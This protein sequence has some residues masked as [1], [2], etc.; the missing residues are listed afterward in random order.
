[1]RKKVRE[2]V[3]VF[4]PWCERCWLEFLGSF[5]RREGCFFKSFMVGNDNSF[6]ILPE[7]SFSHHPYLTNH[8]F[9]ALE[10]VTYRSLWSLVLTS[11]IFSSFPLKRVV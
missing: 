7:N 9:V 11:A 3:C 2:R 4:V 10:V 6:F 1:M 5:F 8:I